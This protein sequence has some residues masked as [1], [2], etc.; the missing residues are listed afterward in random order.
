MNV[1]ELKRRLNRLKEQRDE[2]ESKHK[3]NELKFTYWGG[4][5]LG[6]LKGKISAIENILD[7]MQTNYEK[8][9]ESGELKPMTGLDWLMLGTTVECLIANPND[10]NESDKKYLS[11]MIDEIEHFYKDYPETIEKI[12]KILS[13]D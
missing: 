13:C 8:R 12:K 1:E 5:D 6:Y 4:F 3:G 9:I 2:L 7:D 11:G 10:L